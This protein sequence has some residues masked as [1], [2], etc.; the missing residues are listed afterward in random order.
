MNTKNFQISLSY[1][2]VRSLVKQLPMK[3]MTKLS[4]ELE[5]QV[6]NQTLT[7]LLDS[8]RTD[9]IS[10]EEIDAEVEKVRTEIYEQK[11]KD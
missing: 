1:E 6:K 8:F 3:E 10:Q 9:D 5:K 2:Q 7:K 4:K 11:K